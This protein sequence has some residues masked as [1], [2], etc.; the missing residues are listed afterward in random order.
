MIKSQQQQQLHLMFIPESRP[1]VKHEQRRA[2][3]ALTRDYYSINCS[4]EVLLQKHIASLRAYS[5][6]NSLMFSAEHF[7]IL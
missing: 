2:T 5:N 6:L 7:F 1:S 3:A 4:A